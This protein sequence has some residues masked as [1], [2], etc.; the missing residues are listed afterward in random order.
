MRKQNRTLLSEPKSR[1]EKATGA[2][3]L[4]NIAVIPEIAAVTRN[5]LAMIYDIGVAHGRSKALTSELLAGVFLT[6]MGAG[7]GSLLFMH[8]GKVLVRRATLSA[9]QQVISLLA[10]RITQQALKSAIGKWLP[11]VGA[12]AMAAWSNY[13]TYKIGKKAVEIFEK[14]IV[15]SDEIVEEGPVGLN[16]GVEYVIEPAIETRLPY[17]ASV[18]YSAIENSS[19]DAVGLLVDLVTLAKRDGAFHVSEKA[20]IRQ[21]GQLLGFSDGEIEQTMSTTEVSIF[22]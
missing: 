22:A 9:F 14:E 1:A 13:L 10:G 7:A 16:S 8:G 11:V 18:D 4:P 15:L 6:A 5:Q 2:A 17:T 19:D 12:A 20:Y 3:Q 21:V